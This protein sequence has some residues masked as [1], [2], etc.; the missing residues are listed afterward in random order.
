MPTKRKFVRKS[1]DRSLLDVITRNDDHAADSDLDG[2]YVTRRNHQKS[3][4]DEENDG[5][6]QVDF[7]RSLCVGLLHPKVQKSRN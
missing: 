7:D 3:A 1:P 4:G 6:N 5:K 2:A